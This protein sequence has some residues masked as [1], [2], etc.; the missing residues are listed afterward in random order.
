MGLGAVLLPAGNIAGRICTRLS[1]ALALAQCAALAALV[2]VGLLLDPWPF[3]LAALGMAVFLAGPRRPGSLPKGLV[4]GVLLATVVIVGIGP[5]LL[6]TSLGNEPFLLPGA[7]SHCPASAATGWGTGLVGLALGGFLLSS[8]GAVS[9]RQLRA[10]LGLASVL[11]L[12]AVVDGSAAAGL[13][14]AQLPDGGR[15]ELA[16]GATVEDALGALDIDRSR[17]HAL[18]VNG[19]FE[20]DMTRSLSAEDELMVLA[21]VGGG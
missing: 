10:L 3:S 16:D 15:L 1:P 6:E 2:G 17:V 13:G 19:T 9:R 4:V 14:D 5:W 7:S 18:S 20:R 11:A 21:P 12:P 8:A